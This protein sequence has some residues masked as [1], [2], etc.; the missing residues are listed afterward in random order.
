[1]CVASRGANDDYRKAVAS[2]VS[3][4]GIVDLR[5]LGETVQGRVLEIRGPIIDLRASAKNARLLDTGGLSATVTGP[6]RIV[7]DGLGGTIAGKVRVNRASWTLGTA[8]DDC[9]AVYRDAAFHFLSRSG[10][11]T[12]L[13]EDVVKF[14]GKKA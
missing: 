4:S 1:M 7:S 6:L 2:S 8:A 5:T 13:E 14:T 3:G 12:S 11:F 10:A 9:D